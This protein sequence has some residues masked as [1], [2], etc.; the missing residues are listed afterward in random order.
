MRTINHGTTTSV[1]R[2]GILSMILASNSHEDKIRE[3]T[4]N[5][6]EQRL[7]YWCKRLEYAVPR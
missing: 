3:N 7:E 4:C 5:C 1:E 6:D 2:L